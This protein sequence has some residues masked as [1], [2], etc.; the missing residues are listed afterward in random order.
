MQNLKRVIDTYAG[1]STGSQGILVQRAGSQYAPTSLN[2]NALQ[3][4]YDNLTSQI[5]KWQDKMADR[6]DYY[7]SQ[8]TALEQLM[9]QMN[10]QS[11]MLAGLMG[12]GSY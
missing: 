6:V 5:E 9:S 1:T 11:S 12:G 7:T 10:N 3:T 2:S 8:F 4:E